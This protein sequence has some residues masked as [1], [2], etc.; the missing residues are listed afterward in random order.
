MDTKLKAVV[1]KVSLLIRYEQQSWNMQ[2]ERFWMISHISFVN[3]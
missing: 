1:K 2:N 3:Q